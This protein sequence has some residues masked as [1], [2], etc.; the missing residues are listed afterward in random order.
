MP[1]MY[2]IIVRFV[3]LTE[4]IYTKKTAQLGARDLFQPKKKW[5]IWHCKIQNVVSFLNGNV[6]Y[7]KNTS[8]VFNDICNTNTLINI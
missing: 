5:I 6:T 3:H 2:D 1:E 7:T 8:L 4:H